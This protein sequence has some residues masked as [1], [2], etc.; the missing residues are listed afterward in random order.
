MCK[1][2]GAWL[3]KSWDEMMRYYVSY[4]SDDVERPLTAT[5]CCPTC[6]HSN[7]GSILHVS[8]VNAVNAS[9]ASAINGRNSNGAAASAVRK[10]EKSP[11]SP[12]GLMAARSSQ[13]S[14]F[15][16]YSRLCGW[17][18]FYRFCLR[19]MLIILSKVCYVSSHQ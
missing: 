19:V 10:F 14:G 13:V 18:G 16:C 8:Y 15:R 6:G 2:N 5:E 1:I 4:S 11:T 9:E 7:P 12:G 17:L 3:R